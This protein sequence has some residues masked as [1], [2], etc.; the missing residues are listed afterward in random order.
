MTDERTIDLVVEALLDLDEEVL[1][2][3]LGGKADKAD[4]SAGIESAL[5]PALEKLGLLWERGEVALSQL[6]LAGKLCE[7]VSDRLFRDPPAG[8]AEGGLRLGLAALDDYH[9]LGKRLVRSGLQSARYAVIDYGRMTVDGLVGAAA[10]DRL[11]ILF[12]STL[13]LPSALRVGEL[14]ARL[15]ERGL[16][17]RVIVGGAPF[18]FDPQLWKEVGADGMGLAATDAIDFVRKFAAEKAGG[19]R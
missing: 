19:T 18:R 3:L 4:G 5:V 14:C 2:R 16:P 10:A 7:E 12:V 17:V 6:Y 1:V 8:S 15:K 13:M 11:E 9:L